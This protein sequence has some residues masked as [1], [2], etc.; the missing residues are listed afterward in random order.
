MSL[1]GKQIL[2]KVKD[3]K[4]KSQVAKG[5][6]DFLEAKYK[7]PKKLKEYNFEKFTNGITSDNI[8]RKPISTKFR[9]NYSAATADNDPTDFNNEID[10][11]KTDNT[12][13]KYFLDNDDA[14]VFDLNRKKDNS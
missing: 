4:G 12:D 5:K 2:Y 6:L 3:S 8:K 14:I 13:S 11:V 9:G 10:P 1:K 7:E